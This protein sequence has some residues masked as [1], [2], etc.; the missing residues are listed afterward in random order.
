[1]FVIEY[2]RTIHHMLLESHPYKKLNR[3]VAANLDKMKNEY[4]LKDMK[5]RKSI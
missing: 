3:N 5:D 1:M 2:T 4:K